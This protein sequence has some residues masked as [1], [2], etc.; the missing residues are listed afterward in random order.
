MALLNTVTENLVKEK[1][2]YN[3]QIQT[4]RDIRLRTCY[5]I[6]FFGGCLRGSTELVASTSILNTWESPTR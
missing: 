3:F 1:Q 2:F 5:I 6:G 4:K